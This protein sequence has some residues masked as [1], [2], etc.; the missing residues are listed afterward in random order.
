MT[1]HS[2]TAPVPRSQ[3]DRA[4]LRVMLQSIDLLTNAAE[5]LALKCIDAEKFLTGKNVEG[6]MR[7]E[8]DGSLRP[9]HEAF[10]EY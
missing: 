6:V 4:D 2:A 10:N 8:A 1:S 3:C 7:I 9:G 5:H